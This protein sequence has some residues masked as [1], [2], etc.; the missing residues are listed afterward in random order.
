MKPMNSKFGGRFDEDVKKASPSQSPRRTEL[1]ETATR[2]GIVATQW[3]DVTS[4]SARR[5]TIINYQNS[6]VGKSRWA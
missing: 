4:D 2:F 1:V 3:S 5:D 6:K